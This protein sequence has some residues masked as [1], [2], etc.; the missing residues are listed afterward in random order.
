MF[1]LFN[2]FSSTAW[3]TILYGPAGIGKTTLAAKAPKAMII[4][5]ENGLRAIDLKSSDAVATGYI[6]DFKTF[7]EALDYFATSEYQTVVI[8][9]LTKLE[10]LVETKICDRATKEH[11][12]KKVHES[13]ADLDYGAG[14]KQLEA[15][16][17]LL[18]ERL[19]DIKASGKNS[20]LIAHTKI[21]TVK[22]PEDDPYDTFDLALDKR[23]VEKVKATV[24]YVWSMS[25]DKVVKTSEKT[26]TGKAILYNTI[27]LQTTQTGGVFAKTRGQLEQY[28]DVPN[29][30]TAKEIWNGL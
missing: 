17:A 14:Y 10:S 19:E 28:I 5:L 25:Q 6:T 18:M 3:S 20:I 15:E 1:E 16:F 22:T 29:D 12:K 8:D 9:S 21:V 24:D 13:I 4:N 23:V 11:P 30:E 26:K 2:D 7:S 27:R